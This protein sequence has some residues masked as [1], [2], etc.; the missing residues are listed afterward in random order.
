[1][2]RA[3]PLYSNWSDVV[4]REWSTSIDELAIIPLIGTL[5]D[6]IAL[7]MWPTRPAAPA[8]PRELLEARVIA[9]A[10]SALDMFKVSWRERG[11][12]HRQLDPFPAHVFALRLR[13][14]C[15]RS[16]CGQ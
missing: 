2:M 3:N 7:P 11:S 10:G 14:Q 15:L 13:S 12:S 9:V 4:R 6:E 16:G 5:R 1:M 8:P